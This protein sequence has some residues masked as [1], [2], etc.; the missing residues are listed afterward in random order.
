MTS[1]VLKGTFGRNYND[2][3]GVFDSQEQLLQATNKYLGPNFVPE[4]DDNDTYLIAESFENNQLTRN[5]KA[6]VIFWDPATKQ[7]YFKEH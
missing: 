6:L 4:A 7:A 1:Y 5:T 2:V 3:L